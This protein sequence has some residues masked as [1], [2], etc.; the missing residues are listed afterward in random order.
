MG[1]LEL[2]QI[3]ATSPTLAE[4]MR[5]CLLRAG[6]SRASGSSN[7]VLGNPKAWLGIAYHDVLAK[8]VGIDLGQE[9]LEDVVG[10]LWNQAIAFQQQR[11]DAHILDRRFGLPPSW[12]GYHI[13]RASVQLRAQDLYSRRALARAA[14]TKQASGTGRTTEIHEQEFAAFGGRL[15][16]RPDLICADE[17]IDYKSGEIVEHDPA[18][19]TD[20]VKIAYVR[21]IRIYGYLVRQ[22]LGWWPRRGVL[23]PLVGAGVEVALDPSECEQEAYEAIALLE[24]YRETLIAAVAPEELASPSPQT[25]RW[26]PYKLVCPS[27]WQACTAAWSGQLDGMAVEGVVTEEPAA[28]YEGAARAVA[29]D[30][31][32]GNDIPR[33]VQIAP[34]SAASHPAVE[35]LAA[36]EQ[37]RFVGLRARPDGVLATTQRTLLARVDDLPTISVAR[38][39]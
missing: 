29:V 28:I 38:G 18:T 27:F 10:R 13:A 37:I 20:L 17:V 31:Q 30:I 36:G 16:G 12:P 8:I 33:R 2:P 6:L 21:Q 11:A 19:Q 7:F 34:L 3:R 1:T 24:S 14:V 5:A 4:T 9:S 32:T 26:C 23:L 15:I 25:C 22:N 39:T 35:I